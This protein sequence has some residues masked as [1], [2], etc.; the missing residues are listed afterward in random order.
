MIPNYPFENPAPDGWGLTSPDSFTTEV[1]FMELIYRTIIAEMYTKVLEIGTFKGYS[2]WWLD[3]AAQRIDGTV[4]SVDIEPRV[5]HPGLYA[6]TKF[7]TESSEHHLERVHKIEKVLESSFTY[8]FIFIDGD[9]E[10]EAAAKDFSLSCHVLEPGGCIALHDTVSFRRSVGK[11][12]AERS[13]LR[14]W[15]HYPV[16]RGLSLYFP[17]FPA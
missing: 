3:Q 15:T 7:I 17:E 2:T 10:Y 4:N 12:V 6:R 14:R 9:H 11:L 8:D 13:D 5:A 1:E 16:G